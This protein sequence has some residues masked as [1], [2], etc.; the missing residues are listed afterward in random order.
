MTNLVKNA[1]NFGAGRPIEVRVTADDG[2]ARVVVRDHG[3]GVAKEDLDRIFERFERASPGPPAGGLGLG[4]FI[5]RGIAE[6]HGGSVHAS[7][8]LGRGATFVVEL[9]LGEPPSAAASS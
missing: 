4:L 5:A 7:S 9:P 6:A 2:T 1:I 3:P 8:E